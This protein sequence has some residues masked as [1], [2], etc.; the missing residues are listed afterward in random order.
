MGKETLTQKDKLYEASWQLI[1]LGIWAYYEIVT[2]ILL[3]EF[4]AGTPDQF[5]RIVV[6]AI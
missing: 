5:R 4:T 1:D 6:E 3:T 2:C